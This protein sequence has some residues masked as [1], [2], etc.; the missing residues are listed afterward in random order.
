MYEPIR[1]ITTPLN[2][3]IYSQF[4]VFSDTVERRWSV[5]HWLDTQAPSFGM[6]EEEAGVNQK[7]H[8]EEKSQ[9]TTDAIH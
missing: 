2:V 4:V 1:K 5:Y 9:R 6:K 7:K 3:K 8:N